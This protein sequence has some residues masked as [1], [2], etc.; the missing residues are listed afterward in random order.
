[1]DLKAGTIRILA[2]KGKKARVVGLGPAAMAIVQRWL[3]T[4]KANG[5]NG[6]A[7][8]FCTLQAGPVSPVYVRQL[9]TR[10]AKKAG[11]E[12]RVHPHG[13]RHSHALELASEG[14][15]INVI[16]VQLGHGNAST[17]SGYIE[18]LSPRTVIEHMQRRCWKP[19]G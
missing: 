19:E 3:D 6:R 13:L 5:I 17:T 16:Q 12:K 14:A 9:L 15:P 8:L 11:I 4:R 2:G 18:R 7:P 10:L 1:M